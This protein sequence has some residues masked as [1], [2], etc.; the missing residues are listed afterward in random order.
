MKKLGLMVLFL[1]VIFLCMKDVSADNKTYVWTREYKTLPQ[2]IFEFEDW[3]TFKVPDGSK[4]NENSIQY[5]GELEYGITDHL[6]IANYERWNTQNVVGSDNSTVYEGF[7]FETKYRIGEKGK[8]WLDPLVYVEWATDPREHQHHNEIETKLIL[9]KDIGKFNVTYNQIMESQLDRDGRTEHEFSAGANYEIFPDVHA[10][11]EF[12]GQY[13][14]PGSHGNELSLGPTIAYQ[15]KY[16][17]VALGAL[18]AVNHAADDHQ[19]RLIV[20]VPLPFDT[21]SF[22]KKAPSESPKVS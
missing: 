18:F 20:G 14:A 4:T 1:V 8:Y 5:Q 11:V 19:V 2:G 13:W 17:W 3:S 9:S 22:F 16:F 6:T 21:G 12:T 15:H 7:K 10:G